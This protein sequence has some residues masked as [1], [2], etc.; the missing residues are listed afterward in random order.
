MLVPDHGQVVVDLDWSPLA[1]KVEENSI[2]PTLVY[3]SRI[4]SKALLDVVASFQ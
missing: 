2:Y 3:Q 1:S 4:F